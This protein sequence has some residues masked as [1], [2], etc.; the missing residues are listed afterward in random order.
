M[1]FPKG[2]LLLKN[3]G[4]QYVHFDN[5]LNQAK[6]ARDG[7]LTGYVEIEYPECVEYIF[8]NDGNTVSAACRKENTYN[9]H[10]IEKVI[11][12]AK[13][14]PQGTVNIH[15][16]DSNLLH[17]ILSLFKEKPLFANKSA[18][19]LDME[20][21]FKKLGDLSFGGFLALRKGANYS[22]IMFHEGKPDLIYPTNK[23]KQK[24]DLNTL[25]EL[26]QKEGGTLVSGYK[27]RDLEKQAN[28]ALIELY[29][30][31]INSMVKSFSEIVGPSI[32]RKTLIPSHE[33][34]I[35]QSGLLNNFKIS[36]DLTIHYNPFIA[37]DKEITKGFAIWI[38]Q[39]S[40]S[41]FV[42]LG[43]RTDEIIHNCIKDYRFA[44]KSSKFFEYSKLSRL[45][46]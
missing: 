35:K 39:F 38:D 45:D 15:Q 13:N 44:L 22:F 23:N 31:F 42:V 2:L 3:A 6:K 33:N 26:L 20:F 14:S 41:I 46:I 18:E 32:I 27:G 10:P 1:G 11:K 4:I 17:M 5:I 34:A 19:E 7:H 28:P 21:F 37:T 8:F 9:E 43:R 29:L 24:I 16:I 12:K 40:D 25:I 36:E 30:K